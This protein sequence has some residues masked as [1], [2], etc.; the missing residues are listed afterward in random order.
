VKLDWALMAALVVVIA[1]VSHQQL[2]P[3]PGARTPQQQQASVEAARA[4]AA[5]PAGAIS[6]AVLPFTNMSGDAGQEFFSDG[7]TEEITAALA[8]IPSLRVVART[9]AFSFKGQNQDMRSIGQALSASHLIEGSVRKAGDRVGGE[10]SLK[11]QSVS[12]RDHD[13]AVDQ[14]LV[15]FQ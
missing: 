6:I 7:M 1:L 8:K 14:H 15:K 4:A 10:F 11:L 5:S 12:E 2:A 3:A 9:S 13:N